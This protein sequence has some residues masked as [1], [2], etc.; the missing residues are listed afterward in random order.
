MVGFGHFRGFLDLLMTAA[1]RISG[2]G[3]TN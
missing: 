1:G 3:W 2:L